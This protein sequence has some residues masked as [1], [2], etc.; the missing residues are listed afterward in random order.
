MSEPVPRPPLGP[1][2]FEVDRDPPAVRPQ[3]VAP[4]SPQ[5]TVTEQCARVTP[6]PP[7]VLPVLVVAPP[8]P[9]SRVVPVG[10]MGLG[11][12]FAGWFAIDAA[13][14]I[15]STFAR[16]TVLG[17]FAATTVAAGVG[18]AG[19]IIV[20]EL[21][22]LMRLKS[23][24]AIQHRLSGGLAGMLPADAGATLAEILAVLPQQRDTAAAIETFQRQVQPHH[25][26]AAQVELFSR[27][28]MATLDRRAEA[29]VRSAVLRAFGVTAISPTALSDAAFF[30][31]CGVRMVRGIAASYGHRPTVVTTAHLLRRL[32]LEAG[33]LGA[34]DVASTSLVQDVTGTTLGRFAATT[35]KSTY[36]SY[37]MARL[38]LIVM[39]LCRPVP[40]RDDEWPSIASLVSNALTRRGDSER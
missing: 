32:L 26:A 11:V 8:P 39:E 2:V 16:S 10:L 24:E 21:R 7:S 12:F 22:S 29:H 28:V 23:V 37:R 25:S 33:K 18:G 9:A 27:T 38:G 40:F 36:A 30:L 20:H 31:A 6:S 1:R 34:V 35:A 4:V 14:W 3:I 5:V 17:L 15:A 19:M 13:S